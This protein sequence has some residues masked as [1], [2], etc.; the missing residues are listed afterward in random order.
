MT[1]ALNQSSETIRSTHRVFTGGRSFLQKNF[2]HVNYYLVNGMLILWGF[3]GSDALRL[4]AEEIAWR[5]FSVDS[6]V[7][8]IQI[9]ETEK[10]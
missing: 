8:Q 1:K 10:H 4:Q 2:S 9:D 5:D 7:N 3:V 6:V